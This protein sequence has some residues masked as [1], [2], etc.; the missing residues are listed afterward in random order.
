MRAPLIAATVLALHPAVA[1]AQPHPQTIVQYFETSW[2]EIAARMPELAMAGYTAVWLPPPTKGAEGTA[3]VGFSVFDRFDLG[4]LDQRGTVVTR[5]GSKADAVAMVAEAHK[6]GIEVYFDTVMNHNANPAR[7][8]NPSVALD[9]VPLDGFPGTHPLDYHVLPARDAGN[10][11][12]EVR[13]AQIFGGGTYIMEPARGESEAIVAVVPMPAGTTIPGYTHLARAPRIDFGNA[14][15]LEEQYLSLLGLADFAIEQDAT[16]A[17]P[18][19]LDGMNRVV[20]LPLPRYIRQPGRADVYPNGTPVEEDIR[21][22]MIRWIEWF[23]DV[24]DCDGLRLD[25]IKHVPP[26]FFRSDFTDDPIDFNGAFQR[27]LDRRRGW[28]DGDDDDGVQDGLLFGESFTGDFGSLQLY[29]NT[30]MYLLDFPLLFRM[31]HDNGVFA[32]WGDGDIGQLSFPQGGMSGAFNE[33]GG[34]GRTA[35]VSFVQSHDTHAPAAQPNPAYAFVMTRVGHAVV[36]YDGNHYTTDSFVTPGRVDALGE[37]GSTVITDLLD[38]RRRFARGGMF[39]RFVDG[40]AYVYERVVPTS[41]G[42]GGAT[43]LVAISDDTNNPT[44][45]GEFDPKPLLVTEFPPGTELE[46]VTGNGAVATLRVIDPA[47]V[48]A[49]ALQ[50]AIAHYD[51]SSDF[52]LPATYGLVYLQ[53]PQGPE[54][55]YVAYAPRT[56]PVAMALSDGAGLLSTRSITTAGPRTTP[57]GAPVPQAQ[58][59]PSVLR[60]GAALSVE[61]TTDGTAAA[62]YVSFDAGQDVGALTAETGGD[63]AG[64]IAMTRVGTSDVYSLTATDLSSLA[65]G[66]HLIRARVTRPGTPSFWRESKRLLLIEGGGGADAGMVTPDDSGTAG[67]GDAGLV[68]DGGATNPDDDRDRDGVRDGEDICPDVSDPGQADF[69]GDRVGDACDACGDTPAGVA[70][71]ADGCPRL[72]AEVIDKLDA[73]VGAIIEERFEALL[74]VNGDQLVDAT[75][76]VSAALAGGGQ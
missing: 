17:G 51:R 62:A 41:D 25:A 26:E 13:N 73:I 33:F 14:G 71:D 37:L 42:T 65:D 45:F 34:L 35:G 39:N 29:R 27:N 66:V 9:V 46:E 47:A 48:P 59:E 18:G 5:Y 38:I 76:F 52:P 24:T 60:R 23:G 50:D 8:E 55:N 49:A 15:P 36:F 74:D 69:D 3:D 6:F 32:K 1:S 7:I 72:D 4:D 10:G 70:V 58:I 68:A 16:S 31:A 57:A 44:S 40:D 75:D 61:V 19:P 63:H 30:G 43:L 56:P 22:Y 28:T 53:I 54:R 67:P 20:E 2:S 12:W 21:Q 11:N 64:F